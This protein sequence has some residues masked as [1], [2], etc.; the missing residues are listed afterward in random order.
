MRRVCVFCGSSPGLREAYT[1]AGRQ[2]GSLLARQGIGLVYG[3]GRVG[4][5]GALADAALKGGGEVVGVIPEALMAREL[6]HT[7]LTRL[8]VVGSMHDRKARMAELSDGFAA[9]P[10][11]YGTLEELFEVVTWAQLGLH[12]KPVGLLNVAGYF[13]P[14]LALLGA[15]DREGF[16]PPANRGVL[17]HSS[18]PEHLLSLLQSHRQRR[19]TPILDASQT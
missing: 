6:G 18:D 16:V 11:G 19:T 8:E 7:G 17:L 15:A 9:L 5:M 3:G 2:M 13:D 10:G 12:D 14:L 1:E 4:L